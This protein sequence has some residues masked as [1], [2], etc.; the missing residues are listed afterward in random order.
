MTRQ[1]EEE[2]IRMNVPVNPRDLRTA[3]GKFATGITVI[4]VRSGDQDH[5]MTANSFTSVSID[6]PMLLVCVSKKAKSLGVISECRQFGVSVLA[7]DQ[8]NVSNHFAGKPE[9]DKVVFAS[10]GGVPTIK[11]AI[12][13]FGCRLDAIYDAGDH[14]IL[15]GE[16][17]AYSYCDGRPL[18]YQD[19][20]YRELSSDPL[21]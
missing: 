19:G 13:Q 20:G 16:I 17:S 5:G 10:L 18:L 15:V 6:P 3:F 8:Q 14:A 1:L 11:G 9:F 7:E 21:E 2:D 4:T 12:A